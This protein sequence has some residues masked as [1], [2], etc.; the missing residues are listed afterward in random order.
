VYDTT[1][2]MQY[3]LTSLEHDKVGECKRVVSNILRRWNSRWMQK[4]CICRIC[5]WNPFVFIP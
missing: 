1:G 2:G 4:G 5:H 3:Y